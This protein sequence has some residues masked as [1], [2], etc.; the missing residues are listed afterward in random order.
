MGCTAGRKSKGRGGRSVRERERGLLGAQRVQTRDGARQEAR[1]RQP[2][3]H[4]PFFLS[5][6][7][8]FL[9]EARQKSPTHAA[10]RRFWRVPH[11]VTAMMYKFLAPL[12]SPHWITCGRRAGRGGGG[13]PCE[14]GGGE[15]AGR[16]CQRLAGK[17]RRGA[18]AAAAAALTAPTGRPREMRYFWPCAPPRP[19][20]M[21]RGAGRG[22][23]GRGAGREGVRGALGRAGAENIHLVGCAGGQRWGW[24][25]KRRQKARAAR[26]RSRSVGLATL[27][28]IMST[29]VIQVRTPTCRD[30]RLKERTAFY[31]SATAD[32]TT[33]FSLFARAPLGCPRT[34]CAR[35]DTLCLFLYIF[36]SARAA[37]HFTHAPRAPRP[38][39]LVVVGG[40][41]LRLGDVELAHSAPQVG[42]VGAGEGL[43]VGHK[44]EL[45]VDVLLLRRAIGEWGVLRA[46]VRKGDDPGGGGGRCWPKRTTRG[47]LPPLR[48]Y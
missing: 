35:I 1:A 19:S 11:S 41:Q 31:C 6:G 21:L 16:G 22:G 3:S 40:R 29:S 46:S 23:G 47:S 26:T 30:S 4:A 42:R 13:G 39:P 14:G 7:L 36:S 18:R 12:L 2:R 32:S 25:S 37:P 45:G 34:H 15:A 48:T 43:D 5:S 10:G 28:K 9:T 20:A 17:A 8:P 44:E 27:S 24:R 33:A 38:L